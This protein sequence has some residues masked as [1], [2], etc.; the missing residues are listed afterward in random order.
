MLFNSL[1]DGVTESRNTSNSVYVATLP[2]SRDL[3]KKAFI[4]SITL[5]CIFDKV[6]HCPIA[7][8]DEETGLS[9]EFWI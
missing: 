6:S 5:F 1:T 7:V 9:M 4:E 2:F 8:S 3:S